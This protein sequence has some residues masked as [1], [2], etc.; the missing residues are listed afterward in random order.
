MKAL[1][2]FF[3]A[4]LIVSV[5]CKKNNNDD[6]NEGGLAAFDYNTSTS[7]IVEIGAP[8]HLAGSSFGLYTANPDSGGRL[9]TRGVLDDNA[10]YSNELIL[11]TAS[12]SVFL[13]TWYIGLP[14]DVEIP[15]VNGRASVELLPETGPDTPYMGDPQFIPIPRTKNSNTVI[16]YMGTYNQQGVPDY[17]TVA[18]NVDA[19][20]LNDVNA[21]LPEYYPVTTYNAQ[22][23]ASGNSTDIQLQDSSD[24]WVTF[25]AEGAGYRNVLGYYVYDQ[26]N[27]PTSASGI[28]SIHIIFPNTSF[29]GSGGGLYSGDKVYLGSFGS[30]KAI[31][32][33]LFQNAW[34]GNTQTVNF[35]ATKFYSNPDFN[36]EQNASIRQHLVQLYHTQRDLV[37]I[38]FEDIPRNWGSCDNDFNDLIFYASSNPITAIPTINMPTITGN[39]N[40]DSDNDG[41]DNNADEYPN[42]PTR[43]FTSYFPNAN[44]MCSYAFEDL[45][46]SKGDY[47]FN[48]L[49]VDA[50]YKYVLDASNQIVD[51][52]M[53]F[54]VKH[55]GASFH[56]GFGVEL[57]IPMGNVSNVTGYNITDNLV[58]LNGSGL[59]AGQ[60]NAVIIPFDDAFDNLEDTLHM[61]I[62]LSGT[63]SMSSW[64]QSGLNP[65]IFSNATRGREI[66][67][68]G[69]APTDLMDNTWFGQSAD[70][71]D[72]A[73][74]RYYKTADH[75][76]WGLEVNNSFRVP[77]EKVRIENA[78]LRF[79]NWTNA[80]G[81]QWKDWYE[82]KQGYRNNANL[83]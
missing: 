70:D 57:P 31:G 12:E 21:A 74:G 69:R 16:G 11:P 32:W 83:Q 65:F 78:Y 13:K 76:P 38:G 60:T 42:D 43:A 19:S 20:L 28:D 14:G 61:V 71:S 8:D 63:Y 75:E 73:N 81:S 55:I 6:D 68:S 58:T 34:R 64:N 26:N 48:D 4:V 39:T 27:P 46:P 62:T 7:T 5:G 53:D 15:I 24:V 30:D 67:L 33:V 41:V 3:F 44:D 37:L 52:E 80:A 35:N 18:D 56:N 49:V 51:I 45:W 72:P 2:L 66:H 29:A 17:L 25:V 77:V 10:Q 22:Y 36:P 9:L 59:E 54:Y 82:D 50:Q 79:D 40:N 47:D 23:L 1:K